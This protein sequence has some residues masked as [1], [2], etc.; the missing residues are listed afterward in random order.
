LTVVKGCKT[1]LY[2]IFSNSSNENIK[3]WTI[4]S[5]QSNKRQ[6]LIY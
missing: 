1:V 3:A 5:L 6:F 2:P 4:L